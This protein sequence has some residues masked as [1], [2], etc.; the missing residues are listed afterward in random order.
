MATPEGCCPQRSLK[1]SPTDK[2]I[3]LLQ[4]TNFYQQGHVPSCH[5]HFDGAQVCVPRRLNPV[6]CHCQRLGEPPRFWDPALEWAFLSACSS[7]RYRTQRYR[8]PQAG[9]SGE[10]GE[11]HAP[12]SESCPVTRHERKILTIRHNKGCLEK[13]I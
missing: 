13:V 1:E 3:R 12:R 11:L 2:F 6:G 7:D 8:T 4:M 5:F 9:E 10:S